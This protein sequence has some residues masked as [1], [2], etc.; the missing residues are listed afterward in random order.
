MWQ[1]E[2]GDPGEWLLK[3]PDIPPVSITV[4][5]LNQGR[6]KFTVQ[7]LSIGSCFKRTCDFYVKYK[8]NFWFGKVF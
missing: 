2:R 5:S 4:T 8:A 7:R 1:R 3:R 6:N